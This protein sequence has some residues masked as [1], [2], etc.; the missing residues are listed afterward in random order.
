MTRTGLTDTESTPCEDETM[1]PDEAADESRRSLNNHLLLTWAGP[2][3]III[4]LIGWAGFARFLPP[5]SPELDPAQVVSL[6]SDHTDLIVVGM[7]FCMWGG[8]FYAIFAVSVFSM[9]RRIEPGRPLLSY[10]QLVMGMFTIAFFCWNFMWLGAVGYIAPSSPQMLKGLAD[11]GFLMTFAPIPPFSMQCAFV[12]LVVLRDWS[13]NPLL[14][15][16]VGYLNLWV[17][18]F[19]LPA[20][21]ALLVTSGP[22]AYD[23]L[24][25]FWVP[26]A[27]FTAWFFVMCATMRK[28]FR[29]SFAE[30]DSLD[31]TQPNSPSSP[32]EEKV[33]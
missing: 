32:I 30:H 20:Q 25:T 18:I 9:L 24:L 11:I 23:G 27:V 29:A 4:T 19:F 10:A 12:A 8:T 7:I 21:C 33:R 6:W 26:V 2:L 28:G 14:P 17:A 1:R 13:D 15:R 16:W 5:P 31:E 3:S 22:L